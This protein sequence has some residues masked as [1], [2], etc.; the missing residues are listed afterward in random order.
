[1]PRTVLDLRDIHEQVLNW[2]SAWRLFDETSTKVYDSK[3][4]GKLIRTSLDDTQEVIDV[5]IF[6][7]P[8]HIGNSP[9]GN[10][11]VR[12]FIEEKGWIRAHIDLNAPEYADVSDVEWSSLEGNTLHVVTT[13]S[14]PQVPSQVPLHYKLSDVVI[15]SVPRKNG[16]RTTVFNGKNSETVQEMYKYLNYCKQ[17]RDEWLPRILQQVSSLRQHWTYDVSFDRFPLPGWIKTEA[18]SDVGHAEQEMAIDQV[19][20]EFDQFGKIR[21]TLR[22][23]PS[24]FTKCEDPLDPSCFRF[25][26]TFFVVVG[27]VKVVI[28]YP[29]TMVGVMSTGRHE[30]VGLRVS[31]KAFPLPI[32]VSNSVRTMLGL[33]LTIPTNEPT[34]G[35][36]RA[37]SRRV[38]APRVAG[39]R[40]GQ[41]TSRRSSRPRGMELF[42]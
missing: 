27:R 19:R 29:L 26:L 1:M 31:Q 42:L 30:E 7:V 23:D 6:G 9:E 16:S 11:A 28:T 2:Q 15:K 17:G 38:A 14:L 25:R 10:D 13:D 8:E 4:S 32:D 20:Q 39:R 35:G 18:D 37:R 40:S 12:R 24:I 33:D 34:L 3:F 22:T 5:D 41:S 21:A 36:R